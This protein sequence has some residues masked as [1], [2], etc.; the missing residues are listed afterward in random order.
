MRMVGITKNFPSVL[1]NDNVDF[2][3]YPGEIHAL[4]GENGAGKTTLMNILQGVYTADKGE[5][6]VSGKSVM[7]RNPADARNYGIGM[8]HQ[9]FSLIPVFNVTE[10]LSI[11]VKSG[12]VRLNLSQLEAD[13][14]QTAQRYGIDIDYGRRIEELSVG[15]QQKVEIL[16]LLFRGAR[17]FILDEPTSVLTPEEGVSLFKNLKVLKEEGKAIVI[18]THKF[19]EVFG[20]ADRVT[21]LRRGKVTYASTGAGLTKETLTRAMIGGDLEIRDVQLKESEDKGS[22]KLED[23]T[24]VGDRK[25]VAVSGVSLEA[26]SGEILGIAGVA[27]NGQRELIDAIF[28]L[29]VLKAGD[30]WINGVR[31]TTFNTKDRIEAGLSY[32]PEERQTR[33][34]ALNLTLALNSILHDHWEKPN[35]N[36]GLLQYGPVNRFVR[37]I[38][39]KFSVESGHGELSAK[40]L[41]GGNLGRFIV[42]REIMTRPKYLLVV[43]P[44]SGLDIAATEYVRNA[45]IDCRNQGVGMILISEDLDEVLTL[46]DKIMVMYRGRLS[47]AIVRSDFSKQK[48]GAMMIGEGF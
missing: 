33:A 10:N 27:R 30:E 25:E 42:G 6:F 47:P 18:I 3:I 21:V 48:I 40:S 46:S 2:E 32:I 31:M 12:G 4:L 36:R 39:E 19:H 8:V 37:G 28:G 5:I 14:R 44:T 20:V 26:K 35:V 29:R 45:L 17:I 41:S 22:L 16:K 13:I 9:H 7:I 24:V 1:A 23:V 15:E 43:N 38:I 34:V 11:G